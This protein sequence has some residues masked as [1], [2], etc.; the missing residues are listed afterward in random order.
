MT[1]EETASRLITLTAA[2]NSLDQDVQDLEVL[3][4]HDAQLIRTVAADMAEVKQKLN[5]HGNA[6]DN[7]QKGMTAITA[8]IQT[9]IDRDIKPTK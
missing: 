6:L 5:E 4:K 7:L 3:R 9:L 1:P 8:M 2:H